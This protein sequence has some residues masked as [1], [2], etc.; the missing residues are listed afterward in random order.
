[1]NTATHGD[2]AAAVWVVDDDRSVR[3]V[4]AGDRGITHSATPP[5]NSTVTEGSWWA[6][7]WAGEPLVSFDGETARG[8]GLG[9]GDTVTVSVLGRSITAKVANLRHVEWDRLSI[10]F[11]IRAL[12]GLSIFEAAMASTTNW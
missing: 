9:L 4:L 12:S 6:A 8:L 1:M 10:N 11:F 7:D 2:A 5:A 3:F